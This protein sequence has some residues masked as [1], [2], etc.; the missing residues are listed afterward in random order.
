MAK[1]NKTNIT[2][3]SECYSVETFKTTCKVI[4]LRKEYPNSLLVD[5]ASEAKYAVVSDLSEEDLTNIEELEAYKP[6]V[7]ITPEYEVIRES[8]NNNERERKRDSLYHDSFAVDDERVSTSVLSPAATAES[9]YTINH[10]LDEIRGLP[11]LQGR[12]LYQ[13]VILGLSVEEIAY[14][15]GVT[16]SSVYESLRKAKDSIHRVFESEEVAI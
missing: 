2:I 11:G 15:D 4:D 6:F 1:I 7:V 9:N 3:Q 12:R 13:K 14:R 8:I 16:I 10:I 5:E